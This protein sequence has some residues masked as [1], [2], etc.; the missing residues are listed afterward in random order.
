MKMTKLPRIVIDTNVLISAGLFPLS[1][2]A[3]ALAIA[4]RSFEIAQNEETWHELETR[5]ARK[6]FDRYFSHE[7]RL[8]HLTEITKSVRFFPSVATET[9]S[10]DSDDDK[11]INLA[12]DADAKLILSGD[13]DLL[14]LG[15]CK[16]IEI[17]SP[18]QFLERMR[19]C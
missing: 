17:L 7:R 6:K 12:L 4:L 11:F 13:A 1:R 16:G 18:A 10:R 19:S 5:I 9:V 15:A 2:I 3:E 14:T 8:E